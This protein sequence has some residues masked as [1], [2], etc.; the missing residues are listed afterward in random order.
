MFKRRLGK[1]P[2]SSDMFGENTSGLQ[3]CPDMWELDNG[4]VAV[5]GIRST[6]ALSKFLPDGASCG[7]DEEIVVLPRKTLLGA[8]NDIADM[9]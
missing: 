8:K 7:L 1:D 9:K 2:H 3:S 4:D 5:I 6:S